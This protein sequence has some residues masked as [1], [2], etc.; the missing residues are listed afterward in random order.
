[1][2]QQQM[3][4]LEGWINLVQE[5]R[6]RLVTETGRAYLLVLAYNSPVAADDL[7]EWYRFGSRVRVE[8]EGE[9][10]FENGK[11]H[12]AWRLDELEVNSVHCALSSE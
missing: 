8:Y 9:P 10:N 5:Q 3:K 1:M 2:K 11:A 12:R 7:L 6:F 4:I